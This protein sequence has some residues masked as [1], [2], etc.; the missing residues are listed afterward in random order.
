MADRID[1]LRLYTSSDHR[2]WNDFLTNC[3]RR[4]DIPKLMQ[5][6]RGCQEGMSHL[7][8]DKLNDEKLNIW[9]ARLVRSIEKTMTAIVRAKN[10]NPLDIGI[11]A[12]GMKQ[13][14]ANRDLELKKFI[15]KHSF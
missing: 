4:G 3:K 2:Q 15:K 1:L 7:A 6:L 14:K 12:P 5:I 8:K 11:M 10:P 13:A 9:F